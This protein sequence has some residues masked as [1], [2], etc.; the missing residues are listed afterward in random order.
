MERRGDC[1]RQDWAELLDRKVFNRAAN[2]GSA[3]RLRYAANLC[4][5]T[6]FIIAAPF[7]AI[8][9]VGALVLVEVT[10]GITKASMTRSP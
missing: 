1:R 4:L 8:M 9:I 10:A 6:P 2:T 5:S 3:A 7:S